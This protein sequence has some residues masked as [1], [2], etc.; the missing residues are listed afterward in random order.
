[1]S[2]DITSFSCLALLAPSSG[3][4]TCIDNIK[5]SKALD[6]DLSE[7]FHTVKINNSID[8]FS[9]YV[10]DG[11]SV[12]NIP[13]MSAYGKYFEG[14]SIDGQLLSSD[15]LNKY[16]ITKDT[17]I[18]AQISQDYI[19]NIATVEFNS[20]PTD[21]MLVK[22]QALDYLFKNKIHPLIALIT[23][24]LF[25]DPQKVYEMSL[26]YLGTIYPELADPKAEVQKAQQLLDK[27]FQNPIN[28]GVIDNE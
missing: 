24:G 16:Q 14:W 21:N 13:D 18:T 6:S 20:F 4:D 17:T 23:C 28:K 26:P 5:I 19:E 9:Q 10:Y 11:E 15:D 22:A 1:M 25:S 8:E 3:V 7:V 2:D 27:K 12:A